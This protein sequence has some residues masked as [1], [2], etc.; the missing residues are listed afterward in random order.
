MIQSFGCAITQDT[1]DDSGYQIYAMPDPGKVY[2]YDGTNSP[3]GGFSISEDTWYNILCVHNGTHLTMY[4]NGQMQTPAVTTSTV[5]ADTNFTL[6]TF[7]DGSCQFNGWGWNQ[8]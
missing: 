1:G 8:T 4:A 5:D 2:C 3:S 6:G 7:P